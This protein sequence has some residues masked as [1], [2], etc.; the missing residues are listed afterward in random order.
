MSEPFFVPAHLVPLE[1]V[2]RALKT[3]SSEVDGVYKA[4]LRPGDR[5][6]VATRNSIYS[7]RRVTE[8]AYA[9]SGGWFARNGL[10]PAIL[11][12]HGCTFGGRA[13]HSGLVAARGLFL[14]FDNH[15]VT[16]RIQKVTL[17]RREGWVN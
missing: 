2:P 3:L 13:L 1:N 16:T 6:L 17:L 15:V 8:A 5:V 14:E 9:V 12:I 10:S 7:I 4:E 11:G